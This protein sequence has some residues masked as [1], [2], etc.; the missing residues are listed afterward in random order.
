MGLPGLRTVDGVWAILF[1]GTKGSE[2]TVNYTARRMVFGKPSILR[3][4]TP[5]AWRAFGRFPMHHHAQ[6]VVGRRE[7]YLAPFRFD[8]EVG[9]TEGGNQLI[10]NIEWMLSTGGACAF[11]EFIAKYVT[12]KL[13]G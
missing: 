3:H 5:R 13:T 9:S 1:E 10:E 11:I 2:D 4:S 8:Q 7:V 6:G 12:E